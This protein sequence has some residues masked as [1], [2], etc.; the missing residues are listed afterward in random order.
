MDTNNHELWEKAKAGLFKL[1]K[2]NKHNN[3][4]STQTVPA[5]LLSVFKNPK[6]LA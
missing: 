5:L 3:F 2:L 6:F 4:I 1:N